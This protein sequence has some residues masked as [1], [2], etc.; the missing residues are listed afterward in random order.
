[1]NKHRTHQIDDLAQRV[2][3][4]AL[5]PTWVA[6][7]Q[8]H[9][10]GKDYLVEIG[11][12]NGDL[13]GSSFYAQ[14]KGQE[15][16][17]VSA[18]TDVVKYSLETKYAEY[19]LDKIRDLPVFLVVVDVNEKKGWW[20]FLQPVLEGNQA[21]RERKSIT[22][23]LPAANALADTERL[24][25]AVIE[26]K[27]WLRLHHAESIHDSVVA[28]KE[29]VRR[30]DPRFDVAVSLV[31]DQPVFTLSAKEEVPITFAFTGD[32][33]EI[34]K[35]IADLLDKGAMV[36]FQPG[37]IKVTGSKLFERFEEVG[38]AMQ[39]GLDLPGALTL[40][41]QDADGRDL[42]RLSDVPGRLTGGRKELWFEGTLTNSPLTLKV[43]PIAPGM[44]GSAKINLNVRCWSGQ[45]LRQ[46]AYFDRLYSFF[47][48]VPKSATC[49]IQCQV[50]GNDVFS[51][52]P[53]L[54]TLP[55]AKPFASYLESLWKARRVAEHFDVNPVWSFED[56]DRE[57]QENVEQLYAV[58][59]GTGWSKP[60][61]KVRLTADCL[62]KT[63]CPEVAKKAA[64]PG[65]V[66]FTSDCSYSLMG[67]KF[68]VGRLGR[69]DEFS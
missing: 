21:W 11:E 24:R 32:G 53:A 14:L 2:F 25:L 65:A 67:E 13:S 61:P 41:C 36:T 52:G 28:H 68:E 40:T 17:Q 49:V 31:N 1:M 26:A 33:K 50:D 45:R 47:Q 9:D 27:K 18:D 43:G 57:E 29:R 20:L 38:C 15:H 58:V 48:A 51:V 54:H 56:F 60:M 39:A 30:T 55:L 6:N 46:L 16:A 64:K 44:G 62:R 34:E 19:Y 22:L 63:F 37:E 59:F 8:H 12:E 69:V 23:D 42:V 7:E 5:P 66:R 10:Y 4:E 35:K 3:R